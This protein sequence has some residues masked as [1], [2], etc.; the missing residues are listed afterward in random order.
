M[1]DRRHFTIATR[2]AKH[3]TQDYPFA[4]LVLEHLPS[5]EGVIAYKEGQELLHR[6][7][8]DCRVSVN[9]MRT[10]IYAVCWNAQVDEE[11]TVQLDWA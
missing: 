4:V 11:V 7:L 9:S 2:I 5:A 3:P 6:S 8:R 1:T 10:A